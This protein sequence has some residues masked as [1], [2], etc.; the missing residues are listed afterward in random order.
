MGQVRVEDER[1]RRSVDQWAPLDVH[2]GPPCGNYIYS[3]HVSRLFILLAFTVGMF[4]NPPVVVTMPLDATMACHSPSRTTTIIPVPNV[5]LLQMHMRVVQLLIHFVAEGG[6]KALTTF[7]K[8][9]LI[10]Y[11][12][13]VLSRVTDASDPLKSNNADLMIQE[14]TSSCY[15]YGFQPNFETYSSQS[16]EHLKYI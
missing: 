13:N 7:M 9:F 14:V 5:F 15:D 1:C 6:Q 11:L 12:L 4:E 10:G 8:T 3:T 2:A 16:R